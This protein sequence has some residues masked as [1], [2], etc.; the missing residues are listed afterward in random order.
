MPDERSSASA[1]TG[2]KA[3]REKAI[4]ISLQTW[5]RLA[6][7]TAS[8]I[9][10]SVVASRLLMPAAP[11]RCAGC[12]SRRQGPPH[13]EAMEVGGLEE[14]LHLLARHVGPRQGHPDQMRLAAE[15]HVGAVQHLRLDDLALL[16]GVDGDAA[17]ALSGKDG[18]RLGH[19][20]RIERY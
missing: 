12:R 7:M 2:E 9:G 4:S 13:L 10:S 8:V 6:W 16:L 14:R 18:V 15:L 19:V 17:L 3:E 20:E 1:I 5:P 11:R